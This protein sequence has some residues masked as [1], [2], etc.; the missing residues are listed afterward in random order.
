MGFENQVP[1]MIDVREAGNK[2]LLPPGDISDPL[3]KSENTIETN[4]G[5]NFVNFDLQY[6]IC[7]TYFELYDLNSL[8]S[9]II[10]WHCGTKIGLNDCLIDRQHI[11]RLTKSFDWFEYWY[12]LIKYGIIIS[13]NTIS[14]VSMNRGIIGLID[15][16]G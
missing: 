9:S 12:A 3:K 6:R 15:C 8:V 13:F 1:K 4:D 14:N 5:G 10:Y 2:S 11:I 7:L 16:I